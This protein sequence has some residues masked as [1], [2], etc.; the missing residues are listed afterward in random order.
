MSRKDHWE[1]VYKENSALKVSWYQSVPTKSLAIINR[2]GLEKDENLIDV[3][4][5]ASTL[6]D[7]LVADYFKNITVLD[8]S[9]RALDLAKKRLGEKSTNVIWEA[10]DVTDFSPDKIY[11]LW[12]D[13]AVFH[14]LTDKS[15]REKYKKALESS[16][17][18]G[19]YVIIAT[20]SVYGPI[21]C[22][23]LDI[24]QYDAKKITKELGSHYNIIEEM[25]E[26]HITPSGNEQLFGY[27]VFKKIA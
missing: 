23:G 19:G 3:G 25:S 16:I 4:G 21:K 6:V 18:V 15:D 14:F 27:Y 8:L 7:H 13:R 9:S 11:S 17:R 2:L 20:F 10:R 1:K 26:S 22:S 24:V 5:G 12:H